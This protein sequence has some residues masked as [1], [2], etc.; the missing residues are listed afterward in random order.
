MR[1]ADNALSFG[2]AVGAYDRG[3]PEYPA[4]AI[5]WILDHARVPSRGAVVVDVGAGTG[6]LTRSFENRDATLIAVEPDGLMRERLAQNV[7]VAQVRAGSAEALPLED[8]SADL[9]TFGQA[10]HWVDVPAASAEVARVL[11]PGGSL[12]LIWNQRDQRTDWVA[13][14][15]EIMG[16]SA[17]EQYDTAHPLLGEP[18]HR[19][20]HAEF[21]WEN[22]LDAEQLIAMVASR[23]Y[24]I[25]LPQSDRDLLLARVR[26][27]VDTHP[28]LRGRT[29]F[30][31]PYVTFVTLA[32]LS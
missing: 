5:D 21:A 30:T 11:R 18:L 17:A 12:A 1:S 4:R 6:K 29:T 28:D 27:L 16:S 26:E 24:I 7:P 23:S 15:G 25:A 31:M 32:G 14:L 8:A 2:Q 10:W 20:D 3:R 19:A 9:V 13:R 22:P